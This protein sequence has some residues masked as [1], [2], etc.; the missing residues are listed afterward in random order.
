MPGRNEDEIIIISVFFLLVQVDELQTGSPMMPRR[1]AISVSHATFST[2]ACTNVCAH[3][4]MHCTKL[5]IRREATCALSAMTIVLFHPSS[6][7]TASHQLDY[8][9]T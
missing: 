5:V 6:L 3:Y 9:R 2:L 1:N 7:Q 8:C 4:S